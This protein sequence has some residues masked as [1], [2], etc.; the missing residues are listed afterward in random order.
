MYYFL[1]LCENSISLLAQAAVSSAECFSD[2]PASVL[3][4]LSLT[5]EKSC[6]S[7][8]V[9]ESCHGFQSGMTCEPSTESRGEDLSMSCAEGSPVRT[10]R[11][12]VRPQQD[13]TANEAVSGEKWPE[14]F[15]KLNQDSCSWKTRQLSLL[16]GL[17]EF[18]ATW[19]RW[20]MMQ[21]GECSVLEMLEH[22]TS[23]RGCLSFPTVTASWAGHGPGLSNN[24]ENL[25]MSEKC[26][27]NT[28]AT[29]TDFG[30]R[31]PAALCEWMMMWPI[32][33]S[34]L[35]PLETDKFQQ[36]LRSHGEP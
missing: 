21:G 7:G 3:S 25:R 5:A 4:R 17:D 13:L 20:G 33:W 23:A 2:I 22:D 11:R 32:K 9:T 12:E 10:L 31:W 8:N 36:W 19:P 24:L 29:I 28:L 15:A 30:W 14:W 35:E 27:W 1:E 34:A 6:S 16:E 18:C 26:T